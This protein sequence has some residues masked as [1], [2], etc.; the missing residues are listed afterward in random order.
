VEL[1]DR[2]PIFI[3][4][5]LDNSLRRRIEALTGAD[6]RYVSTEDSTF[7]RIC[8]LGSDEYI[9]KVVDER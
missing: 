1:S 5:K 6:R 4:H 7:L 2:N 9:G 3:G 8:R